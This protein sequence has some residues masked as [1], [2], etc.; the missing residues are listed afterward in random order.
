MIIGAIIFM[1]F[2]LRYKPVA[3]TTQTNTVTDLR[4]DELAK[5]SGQSSTIGAGNQTLKIAGSTEIAGSALFDKDVTIKGAF[6]LDGAFSP[7]SLN[8]T[9]ATLLQSGATLTK[10]L[11]LTGNLNVTGTSTFNGAVTIDSLSVAKLSN[12]GDFTYGRHLISGGP[13]PTIDTYNGNSGSITGSDTAG[14]VSVSVSN[15]TPGQLVRVNFRAPFV[16]TPRV[17][18]TPSSINAASAQFYVAKSV[19]GFTIV[20]VSTSIP[21]GTISSLTAGDYSFDYLIT[22]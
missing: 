2:L 7:A 22:Q 6:N 15:T 19:N 17:S 1:V 3:N 8:V 9:G 14:S 12:V 21:S 16:S 10:F 13:T 11:N 20:I 4:P 18:L 5:V